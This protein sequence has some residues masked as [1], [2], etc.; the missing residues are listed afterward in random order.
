MTLQ[1]T[2]RICASCFKRL[3]AARVEFNSEGMTLE[4]RHK[5]GS[6]PC[7]IVA[8]RDA[9]EMSDLLLSPSTARA[10]PQSRVS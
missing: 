7:T 10:I 9:Q 4:Y 6:P 2:E 1:T 5:D 3:A 8:K